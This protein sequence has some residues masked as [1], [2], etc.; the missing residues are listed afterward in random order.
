MKKE[1]LYLIWSIEHDA[2]WKAGWNGYTQ[3]IRE[4]G[5]YKEAEALKI[6]KGANR[7]IYQ[8]SFNKPNEALI[9]FN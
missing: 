3:D 5:A 7:A 1:K 4:A 6:L 9:P 2:W 8:G